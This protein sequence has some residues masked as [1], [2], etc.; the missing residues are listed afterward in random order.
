MTKALAN[1]VVAL[2]VRATLG[3]A[4]AAPRDLKRLVLVL[5][6]EPA[7]A[8]AMALLLEVSGYQAVIAACAEEA[9]RRLKERG[10]GPDLLLCDY[11]LRKGANGID[12]I[13]SIRAMTNRAVPAILVTGDTSQAVFDAL[14]TVDGCER[15]CKPVDVDKLL[16]LM[17][18]LL[19][20]SNAELETPVCGNAR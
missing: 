14:G 16:T 12:A 20:G 11:R 13:Q 6:D 8:D 9:L 1:K 2:Q 18:R 7:V 17:E 19:N 4:D 15:I 3:Q 5:D 10:R